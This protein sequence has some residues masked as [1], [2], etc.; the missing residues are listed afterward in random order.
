MISKNHLLF[1]DI[2]LRPITNHQSKTQET[3][4]GFLPTLPQQAAES[5]HLPEDSSCDTRVG[6]LTARNQRGDVKQSNY[7]TPQIGWNEGDDMII[8]Q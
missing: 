6:C 7:W 1:L 4:R 5:Q 8:F 3:H 2:R